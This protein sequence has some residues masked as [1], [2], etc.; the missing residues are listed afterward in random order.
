MADLADGSRWRRRLRQAAAGDA[1][2]ALQSLAQEGEALKQTP[3]NLV[4]LAIALERT[5]LAAATRLLR[6]VQQDHP[7]DFWINFKLAAVLMEG[8]R[9]DPVDGIRFFQAA[10]ALRPKAPAVYTNLCCALYAQGKLAEAGAACEKAIS[11]QPDYAW[12]HNNFGKVLEAQGKPTAAATAYRRAIAAKPDYADAH[13]NLGSLLDDQGKPAEAVAALAKAVELCPEYAEAHNNLGIALRNQGKFAEAVVAIK[14]AV[15]LKPDDAKA[16]SNLGITLR[17]LGKFPEAE[18]A[19]RRAIELQPDLAGAYYNLGTVLEDEKKSVEAIAAYRQAIA[20]QPKYAEAYNNLGD[21][22]CMQGKPAEAV[23]A[24]RKA[25][26]LKS[27]FFEA[28][29]NLAIALESQGKLAEAADAYRKAISING[30]NAELHYRLG[31][32]LRSQD[33]LAE[34]ADAYRKAIACQAD[35]AEAYCNLGQTLRREGRFADALAALKKGDALGSRR[36]NWTYPSSE[37]VSAAELLVS[38]DGK[39]L[40][41]LKGDAQPAD[42]A[43]RMG[44]AQMCHAYK[45]LNVTAVNFYA[46][47]F[48]EQ[49]RLADDVRGEHRYNAACAAALAASGRGA[50]AN[51]LDDAERGR[52]RRQALDWLTSDLACW[53]KLADAAAAR[54]EVRQAIQQWQKDP[55]LA[56]LREAGALAKLTPIERS[57]WQKLWADAAE[58]LKRVEGPKTRDPTPVMP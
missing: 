49:P 41:V 36:P 50:D 38:L 39:L 13:Y 24:L 47:S 52:L 23:P 28:Y 40:R 37:W 35:H 31:N 21:I 27:D 55:D 19:I 42:A 9:P 30:S 44:M 20:R 54:P 57:A 33:K 7:T 4:L 53:A 11:L 3:T 32:L 1:P 5:D 25:I 43:E 12:A 2:A 8:K 46:Q 17:C 48:A 51:K 18:A 58:L 10:L 16:F 29:G 26:D 6:R 22:L 34:A 15:E 45:G 56:G 14:K